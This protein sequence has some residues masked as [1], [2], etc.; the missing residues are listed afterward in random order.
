M[1]SLC[2]QEVSTRLHRISPL[3]SRPHQNPTGEDTVRTPIE[4][5]VETLP[6]IAVGLCMIDCGVLIDML[7][8]FEVCKPVQSTVRTGA[9]KASLNVVTR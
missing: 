4:N 3:S 7:S 9:F 5:A 6:A 2:E 1:R 8:A